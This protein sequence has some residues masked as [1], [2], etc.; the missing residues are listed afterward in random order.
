MFPNPGLVTL[1]FAAL[2]PR[3]S[4]AGRS[5]VCRPPVIGPFLLI[6]VVLFIAMS[7]QQLGLQTTSVTNSG[8]LTGLHVVFTPIL[9]IALFRQWS[10]RI[11]WPAA[12]VA[13]VGIAGRLGDR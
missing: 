3:S 8:F 5:Q 13:L 11:V 10:H 1:S 9:G 6:G 4:F 12:I 7:F 2:S